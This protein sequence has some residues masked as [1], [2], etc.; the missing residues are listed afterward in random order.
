[1]KKFGA[2][3]IVSGWG[4]CSSRNITASCTTSD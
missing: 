3:A 2:A 1:M 4:V